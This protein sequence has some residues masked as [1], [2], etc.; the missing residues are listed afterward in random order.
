MQKNQIIILLVGLIVIVILGLLYVFGPESSLDTV[1]DDSHKPET[2]LVEL[3]NGMT[4][5][6]PKDATVNPLGEIEGIDPPSLDRPIDIPAIF[7]GE[8]KII[9]ATRIADAVSALENDDTLLENWI[10]LANLRNQIQDHEG[11]AEIYEYLNIVSP[12]NF[13]SP[14]NLGTLYHLHLKEF[15]KSEANFLKAIELNSTNEFA[16]V[17]LH[18]LYRYSFKIDTSLAEDILLEGISVL[19]DTTNLRLTLAGYYEDQDELGK[20]EEMYREVLEIADRLQDV[21]LGS[22]MEAI[23]E[24]F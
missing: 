15:E 8:A 2:E 13:L 12:E 20:A 1:R 3:P 22:R 23:L 9:M 18:E 10:R 14:L 16:Y 17:G 7:E 21:E 11:A 5:E 6:V 4:I 19:S 24:E